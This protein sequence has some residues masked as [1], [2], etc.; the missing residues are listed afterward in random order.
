MKEFLMEIFRQ[1][2]GVQKPRTGKVIIT[3]YAHQK[4]REYQLSRF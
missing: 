3:R 1:I 4:M 2:F